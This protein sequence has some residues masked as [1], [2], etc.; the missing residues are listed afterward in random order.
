MFSLLQLRFTYKTIINPHDNSHMYTDT[1][2]SQF[3]CYH[4]NMKQEKPSY[5][6]REMCNSGARYKAHCEQN[7]SSPIPAIDIKYV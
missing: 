3:M 5:M 4:S 1:I 2:L 6:Q 7:L